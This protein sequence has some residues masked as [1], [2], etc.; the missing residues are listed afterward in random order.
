MVLILAYEESSTENSN[1]APSQEFSGSDGHE[2]QM[3]ANVNLLNQNAEKKFP[4]DN[5]G[6]MKLKREHEEASRESSRHSIATSDESETGSQ[7]GIGDA[8]QGFGLDINRKFYNSLAYILS[9]S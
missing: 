3:D 8:D 4:F 6:L 7:T 9:H 2:M 5:N 1:E